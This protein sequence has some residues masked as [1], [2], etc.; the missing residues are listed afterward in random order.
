[1]TSLVEFSEEGGVT[2]KTHCGCLYSMWWHTKYRKSPLQGLCLLVLCTAHASKQWWSQPG[3]KAEP[4][5][6]QKEMS[7]RTFLD[8][9]WSSCELR[10]LQ[11]FG[12]LG[13]WCTDEKRAVGKTQKSHWSFCCKSSIGNH[14]SFGHGF[15]PFVLGRQT[16]SLLYSEESHFL[17]KWLLLNQQH[18]PAVP[19]PALCCLRVLLAFS[20]DRLHTYFSL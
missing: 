19:L 6:S 2:Q 14:G 1:M 7:V 12:K 8:W 10:N 13:L 3:G 18:C 9:Q 17:E 20:S 5:G 4:E 15:L 11:G 16:R